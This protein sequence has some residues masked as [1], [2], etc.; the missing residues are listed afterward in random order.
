MGAMLS[1][2]SSFSVVTIPSSI[3]PVP[4]LFRRYSRPAEPGSAVVR[5]AA[6]SLAL[7]GEMTLLRLGQEAPIHGSILAIVLA[8]RQGGF[9]LHHLVSEVER[10]GRVGD[11]HSLEENERIE[12]ASQL[13]VVHG[14]DLSR[15]RRRCASWDREFAVCSSARLSGP[16]SATRGSRSTTRRGSTCLG[17][18]RFDTA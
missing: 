9:R 14:D 10:V 1:V 5:L 3:T 17:S 4:R 7:P 15:P 12:V 6:G 13:L 16:N 18:E 2:A 8:Q 11:A